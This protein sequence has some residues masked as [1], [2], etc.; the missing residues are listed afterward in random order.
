M[1][2]S[3]HGVI[4]SGKSGSS[5]WDFSQVNPKQWVDASNASSFTEASGVITQWR[6]ISGNSNHFNEISGRSKPARI[7]NELNGQAIVSFT[8]DLLKTTGR[9]L[10]NTFTCFLVAKNRNFSTDIQGLAVSQ[11]IAVNSG[12]GGFYIA[13]T[14]SYGQMYFDTSNLAYSGAGGSG[15]HIYIY[16]RYTDGT[17]K[18]EVYRD[19]VA[20]I[21]GAFTQAPINTDLVMGGYDL[22]DTKYVP[23]DI[24]EFCVVENNLSASDILKGK[25]YLAHK[26]GLTSLL[27]SGNIYKTNPPTV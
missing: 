22:S 20:P 17:F 26:W 1:I 7:A 10:V 6:D 18:G 13:R 8:S 4:Q 27:D 9:I 23:L 25:G 11:F 19:D 14:T 16:K 3:N 12:R 5:L 21:T 24:A 2:L 15:Y